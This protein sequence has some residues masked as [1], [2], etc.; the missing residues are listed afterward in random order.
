MEGVIVSRKANNESWFFLQ[1]AALNFRLKGYVM[2]QNP[3]G[4]KRS[5]NL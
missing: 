2:D 3:F 1:D 4:P 5:V